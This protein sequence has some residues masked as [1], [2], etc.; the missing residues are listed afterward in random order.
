PAKTVKELIAFAK[1]RPGQLLYA[2]PGVGSPQ[3]LA[4]ELFKVLADVDMQH[5]P[6]KGSG[7]SIT[8]LI[9][10]LV[11]L[12]FDQISVVYPHAR[13]GKLRAIA[14]TSTNRFSLLPEIP[15][16]NESGLAGFDVTTWWG[17]HAPAAV[18]KD[19]IEKLNAETVRLLQQ[20]DVKDKIASVGA[21]AV[22]NT[23]EEFAAFLRIEG[24][25]FAR[26]AKA[27]K[28]KME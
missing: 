23:P 14:V 25:K 17:L 26:I 15:T 19:I 12:D 5:I 13:Q 24:E 16:I 1:A 28:L 27:A 4:G 7:Q 11:H 8:D 22:G 10:G 21:E 9:A 2:S 3:H 20:A 18:S 6:Y